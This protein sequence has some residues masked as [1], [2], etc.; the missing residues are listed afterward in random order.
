MLLSQRQERIRFYK[1]MVVGAIGAIIDFGIMNLLTRGAHWSL[2][3][4]GTVSF[5]CAVTSNF[6]W[7]RYWTYPDSRSRPLAQQWLMFVVVN[8]VGMLIRIPILHFLEPPL[9]TLVRDLPLQRLN[10]TFVAH[11]VTLGIAVAIVMLWNFFINRYWTYN[12]VDREA[13]P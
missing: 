10:S 13:T 4:A 5:I 9:L 7:N 11:N 3:W 8:A 2:L 1:F 12:D 6:L